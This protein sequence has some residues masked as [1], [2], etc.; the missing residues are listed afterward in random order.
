M[1]YTAEYLYCELRSQ[2]LDA[3]F[4]GEKLR[5]PK[6]PSYYLK[7][8]WRERLYLAWSVFTGKMDAVKWREEQDVK[9]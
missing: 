6:R 7:D 5:H 9:G 1:I 3:E 4:D 2:K 8:S